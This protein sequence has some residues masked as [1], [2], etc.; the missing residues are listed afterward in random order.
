MYLSE[1]INQSK[2]YKSPPAAISPPV[3]WKVNSPRI[4]TLVK[5][6]LA[7]Q[8][9]NAGK[10]VIVAPDK[11]AVILSVKVISVAEIRRISICDS[12]F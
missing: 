9:P 10:E 3:I 5:T 1:S 4:S 2:K 7:P 12:K 6:E 11:K 8:V